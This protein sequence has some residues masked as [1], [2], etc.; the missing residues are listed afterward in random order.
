MSFNEQFEAANGL[1]Y[2][3]IYSEA[4]FIWEYMLE[5]NPTNANILYKIGMCHIYLNNEK[6]ALSYF[7]KAQYSVVKNYN[8]FSSL[9]KNAPPE[10]YYYL[11]KSNHA[12]GNI[13]TALYQYDFFI[14]NVKKKHSQYDHGVLGLTQCKNAKKMMGNP[15]PYIIRN[16][17]SIVNTEF[18]EYSPVISIDG[19]SLFFTSK[20]L[21]TDSS[22]Y[23][24]KNIANGDYFEDIYVTYRDMNGKW[25]KPK[26]LR[27]CDPRKNNA[28]I[29]V[30]PDGQEI[31]V[32]EDINNGD[33]YHSTIEDTAFLSLEPFPA[34]ELNTDAWETHAT[35]SPDG[36]SLYF[37]SDREG[38]MGGRDI[39]RIKIL[40]NGEWSKAL[41]LGPPINSEFDEDAPF[42]G[43]DSKTMYFS[44]NGSKSM[45]GF[46]IFVSIMDE[47]EQWS[48]PIN[49]GYPLNSYDDDIFYTTTADGL[50]G[51]YSSDKLDGQ[52]DKDI[53]IV[54]TENSYVKNVAI[55][56]GFIITNDH[57]MIPK[58]VTIE[59]TDLTDATPTRIYRPRRRDGGYVLNLKPCHTYGLDYK[60]D[61]EIFYS[62]EIY[63]PCNSSYQ[64]IKHELL[65]D[66]I[67]L[68]GSELTAM[69]INDQRWEFSNSEYIKQLEGQSVNIYENDSLIYTD[70][71][72]KYGQ[73]PY[74][75]LDPTKS[76][77]FKL[78]EADFD[79]CDDLILNLVDTSNTILDTYTFFANCETKPTVTE[80]S[81][82]LTTPIFQYNFG[83]NA[84]KFNT[85]NEA[86]NLYVQ[87]IKQLVDAGKE[88][89]I[90]VYSSASKV[91]TKQYKSN[92]DLAVKRRDSGKE[93]LTKVL[94]ASGIDMTKIKFVDKSAL[95]QG[96]DY[97]NDAQEKQHVYQ[98]Y[99][100][101][102]FEIQ[103]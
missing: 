16:I 54:E 39:Y 79:F 13:D 68:E 102:K 17:G 12:K 14:T 44:S 26:Y 10:L 64:E 78:E 72:N 3:K 42:L 63:V 6:K 60:L 19:S 99:Q 100:Y 31:F 87:G 41:N 1:M 81:T 21:R 94:K 40:P 2:D 95:V 73:F 101:I 80:F 58:G 56:S 7:E 38:G 97:N 66:L 75:S 83:Y 52:G 84:D 32:Y 34:E 96:P 9:E 25:S 48:E 86:L 46:D 74:K 47:S 61:G 85:K 92:Y 49:L 51:F 45:G 5:E 35:I 89:T 77:L 70:F 103:F 88:V 36:Q 65:L 59:V 55:L 30:S 62:T 15:E 4:I 57:S 98:R 37:V 69:P 82:I 90:L 53:Y 23:R 27:F 71:I 28:S 18:A 50:T 43:A 33:I 8:P 11:A 20:R 91:P 22:N 93:T 24:Y 29:S 67:N 76:H